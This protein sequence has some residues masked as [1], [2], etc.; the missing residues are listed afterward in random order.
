MTEQTM[1]SSQEISE[2]LGELRL[3]IQ[4]NLGLVELGSQL[5]ADKSMDFFRGYQQALKDV[6]EKLDE[7]DKTKT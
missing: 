4:L 2:K 1:E 3:K 7:P 6:G 5:H